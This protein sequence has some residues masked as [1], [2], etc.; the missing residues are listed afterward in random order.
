MAALF[1]FLSGLR[2]ADA[3]ALKSARQAKQDFQIAATGFWMKILLEQRTLASCFDAFSNR[4]PLR[5]K[6]L[7]EEMDSK[8]ARL[9]C[10]GA[11]VRRAERQEKLVSAGGE[12]G[13]A[14]SLTLMTKRGNERRAVAG[15]C[16]QL[17]QIAGDP[18]YESDP[19]EILL[20]AVVQG[21]EKGVRKEICRP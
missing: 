14:V 1:I 13:A 3:G 21:A 15:F 4:H 18:D 12:A 19:R 17:S 9:A 2:S 11:H 20:R 5:R 7:E 8:R 10:R 6:A 16:S